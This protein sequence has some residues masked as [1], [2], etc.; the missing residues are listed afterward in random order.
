MAL[1]SYHMRMNTPSKKLLLTKLRTE[2]FLL[3]STYLPT[4]NTYVYLNRIILKRYEYLSIRVYTFI[5]HDLIHIPY[6][7]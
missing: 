2:A 3:Y 7:T 4:F 5:N 6:L 1:L